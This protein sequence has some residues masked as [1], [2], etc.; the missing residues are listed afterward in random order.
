VSA[1]VPEGQ[2]VIFV[3]AGPEQE[4]RLKI[5][6]RMLG[7]LWASVGEVTYEQ[8][9][10]LLLA[11]LWPRPGSPELLRSAGLTDEAILERSLP[12][13]PSPEQRT[14]L[15]EMLKLL[16]QQGRLAVEQAGQRTADGWV[17]TEFPL[18]PGAP[19]GDYE[20]SAS[21]F[22]D[23]AQVGRRTSS[24]QVRQVGLVAWLSRLSRT[25]GLW[26][27][28]AAVAVAVLAGLLTGYIFGRGGSGAH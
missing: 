4:V 25:E 10:T 11:H 19:L 9:P 26:Y 24:L 6:D 27:G 17:A 3:L 2:E 14:A 8:A 7:L 20:V 1:P 12:A 16:R 22:Q 5:K 21:F 18:P 15:L 23:G 28:L 13:D